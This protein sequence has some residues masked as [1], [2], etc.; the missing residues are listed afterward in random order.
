[1][2]REWLEPVE[3]DVPAD[4][5]AAVGG[6]PLVAQTLL[7]R[8]LGALDAARA[9]LDPDFYTP[10]SPGELPGMEDAV[11]RIALAIRRRE[12]ICVWGDFDVDGQT[13]TTLMVAVLRGLG[14][15]VTFHI[16]VRQT[17]SHGVNVPV[18]QGIIAEGA[19]LLLT[20]D[21]GIAAHE[22]IAY[23]QSRGV[24]VIVTDH[25]SLPAE[26]PPAY[27][28]VNPQF[29]PPGHP[30]AA[31]PGVGVAYKLAEELCVRAGQPELAAGQLDL[32]AL[33]IV[34]D[35]A[36]LAGDTRYLLQRGLA[37]L[38][39][40]ARPGL[41]AMLALNQL[42]AAS[43]N[44]E[45]IGFILAPR[46]NALGRLADANRAVEFLTTG[47]LEQARI[48]AADLESLNAQRKLMC[49]QV[50]QAAEAQI[51]RDPSLL[52][53]A[54][55]VLSG[56]A[57]PAGVIGI[58]AGRLA[59]RYN[60]PAVLFA[61]PPGQPARGSA[62]SVAGCNI[63]AAIAAQA[64]ML[65]GFGGHP[66]AAGLSLAAGH[67]PEFRRALARTVAGMVGAAPAAP[68]LQIDGYLPLSEL[69]LDLVDD[70]ERLA[71]MGS[72][73]PPLT[74]VARATWPS[75]P[76]ARSVVATNTCSYLSRTPPAQAAG[77]SGG[78]VVGRAGLKAAL[79]WPTPCDQATIA[80]SGR[81]RWSGSTRTPP[82]GKPWPARSSFRP[83]RSCRRSRR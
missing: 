65:L 78:A 34:A 72:G 41:Q 39:R 58:V 48:L 29:L 56:P 73:N 13:A 57:W 25:H 44:E 5:C 82:V 19:H 40:T 17:E 45:H 32:V 61:A 59:E 55:L 28:A 12:P 62:R 81:C 60:R 52:E 7:R 1:M 70:L 71:P 30:L 46:L 83:M 37:A 20:C 67:I 6:H 16:P 26:L 21:T 64:G 24:D 31:L 9:F 63:T 8:G 27:A 22:A 14:A 4:F 80:A 54:A 66:M 75:P 69:S 35:V 2:V 43:L 36:A 50:Y 53:F 47:E 15:R 42:D 23:A 38:R 10:A 33:G 11:K 76:R 3:I 18:L 51:E 74:L 49:D 79:T 68:A 77:S